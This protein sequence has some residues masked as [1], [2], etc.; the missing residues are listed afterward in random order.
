IRC[1]RHAQVDM[2]RNLRPQNHLL[3]ALPDEEHAR[4]APLLEKVPGTHGEIIARPGRAI[5]HAYFPM[6]GMISVVALMSDGLGAEVATVGNEGMIGLPIFLGSFSTPFHLM[7]QLSGDALRIRADDLLSVAAPPTRLASV[8]TTYSQAFF[9]QTAQNVAC[10]GL[11]AVHQRA[12][13]WLLSTHDRAE[14]DAFRLTHEF[15]AFMLG[16]TRQSASLAVADFA[17]RGLIAYQRGH[18]HI[19]DR[20]RLEAASCECYG[21]V[22]A[23]FERLLGLGRG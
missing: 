9:V 10:N 16:V 20:A 8:L 21:I 7:W 5:D 12:A 11:H 13:R 4:L 18:M 15:L 6:S 17:R 19:L 3:S 23:E 14:G 22:R 2:D 1:R